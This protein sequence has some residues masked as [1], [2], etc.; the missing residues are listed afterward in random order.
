[1]WNL[2]ERRLGMFV[3]W[4]VYSVGGVHEQ[5]WMRSGMSKADYEDYARHFT[6]ERFDP[7]AWIDAAESFHPRQFV[8]EHHLSASRC[9]L[10]GHNAEKVNIWRHFS[11]FS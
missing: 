5:E 7:D 3:H 9:L 10:K 4:G 8:N 11:Y 6:G 1:M 2:F